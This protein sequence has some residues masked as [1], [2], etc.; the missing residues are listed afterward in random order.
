LRASLAF[1]VAAALS[2]ALPTAASAAG[3]TPTALQKKAPSLGWVR[4][5]PGELRRVYGVRFTRTLADPAPLELHPMQLGT[6][7]I[8]KDSA[9][10]VVATEGGLLAAISIETGRMAWKRTDL[11]TLGRSLGQVEEVLVVGSE[12]SLVG[13]E[14]QSG[15]TLWKLDVG[16]EVGA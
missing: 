8:T 2:S 16:G 15:K 3:T 7:F 11:G 9:L 5:D 6:P 12:S 4:P 10:A 14:A 13:L 1:V